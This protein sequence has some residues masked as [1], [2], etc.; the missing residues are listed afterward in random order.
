ME[1][2]F[3]EFGD[4]VIIKQQ[5]HA[6]VIS[7]EERA[8]RVEKFRSSARRAK[9]VLRTGD[10]IRVT[11]CPGTKRWITF[12]HWDGDWIVSK[13]GIDD[14]SASTIDRLNGDPVSF[15]DDD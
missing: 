4:G 10:R 13:S 5:R 7:E 14:Y 15:T 2:P 6:P 11:K 9:R 8:R 1:T 12:D 3:D